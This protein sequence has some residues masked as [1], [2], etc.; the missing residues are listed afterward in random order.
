MLSASGRYALVLNGE[1]YNHSRLRSQFLSAGHRF[2][3]HS[4]TEVLLALIERDGVEQA[5][6]ACLG[7]F[8]FALW[9]LRDRTLYLARDRFGEKPLYYGWHGERFLFGSELKALVAHPSFRKTIDPGALSLLLRFAYVPSPY[10]IFRGTYKVRP[11]ELLTLRLPADG[12]GVTESTARLS[13]RNYWTAED[14]FHRGATDPFRGSFEK[15]VGELEEL[16]LDS[17]GMQMQADVPLGAFLS[18]GIDSSVVVAL[19]QRLS[20]SPTKTFSIGFHDDRFNEAPHAKVVA[21]HLG[22]DHTELYVTSD[23]ALGLIP[24]LARMYDEPLGDSSQIPTH[25]VARLAREHVTVSLS[26]DGG[27]EIFCGYDKYYLGRR[28]AGLPWRRAGGALLGALPW[29]VIERAANALPVG[30]KGRLSAARLETLH[31]LLSARDN[32]AIAA[33]LSTVM[34]HPDSLTLHPGDR[35][36]VFDDPSP[37]GSGGSFEQVAMTLDRKSY[38]SDDVL[39][40]VDRASMAVALESRA[41]LLDP[42]ISRFVAR[43]PLDFV[44]DPSERKKIL[45][46]VLYRHVP[47]QL[48][49]RPKAGFSMPVAEWLRNQLRGWA[50]GLLEDPSGGSDELLDLPH[51]RALLAAHVDRT[52]DASPVLW[53]LLMFQSWR[54]QWL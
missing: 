37:N 54:R 39:A 1:I 47:R 40:K 8:A 41:P 32:T 46:H 17:V 7:M 50:T 44:C 30:A 6:A 28:F 29:T 53:P 9:D 14:D 49:D 2:C 20:T 31:T 35:L 5:L 19:M 25:L 22:T 52:R 11:G 13:T 3:G 51:C 4:D 10:C 42:R 27:D 23:D 12:V 43:L 33:A 48:V 36:T 26:G 38:L 24:S 21:Q 15:A 34:R 16:L 45:R 18:G